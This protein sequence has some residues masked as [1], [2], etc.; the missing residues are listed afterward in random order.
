M[1]IIFNSLDK[2]I[3]NKQMTPWYISGFKQNIV[4]YTISK[5]VHDLKNRGDGYVI[6]YDR[7]WR[8]QSVPEAMMSQL[9][10]LAKVVFDILTDPG[11]TKQLIPEY[12]KTTAC[13]EKIRN[14]RVH[15][16]DDVNEYTISMHKNAVEARRTAAN[17]AHKG[18]IK[19]NIWVVQ[20]GSGYWE[21]VYDWAINNSSLSVDEKSVLNIAIRMESTR[22]P[23][24]EKQG[25]WIAKINNKLIEEGFDGVMAPI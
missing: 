16:N 18:R 21:N 19:L 3:A 8:N 25:E 5:F 7:I 4:I 20:Q 10:S 13:W 15:L 22:K 24:T 12:A 1:A 2:I 9:H 23:P 6:D 11:R 17:E 14:A